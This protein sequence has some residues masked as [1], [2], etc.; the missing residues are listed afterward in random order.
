VRSSARL[1]REP[2]FPPLLLHNYWGRD[3]ES[4]L[5]LT[6][7]ITIGIAA[8]TAAVLTTSRED[9]T[10]SR[11]GHAAANLLPPSLIVTH[12]RLGLHSSRMGGG[13]IPNP[14]SS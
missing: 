13:E 4:H 2:G 8:I 12:Y 5:D 3:R 9:A 7:V 1:G 10:P 11:E 6:S 14:V